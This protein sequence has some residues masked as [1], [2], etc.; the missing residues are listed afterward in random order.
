MRGKAHA[1]GGVVEMLDRETLMTRLREMLV[2]ESHQLGRR[3][4]QHD[5]P[6]PLP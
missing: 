1:D 6:L 2:E 4:R 3:H 5:A